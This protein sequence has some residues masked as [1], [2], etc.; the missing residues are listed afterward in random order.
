MMIVS[1]PVEEN[2]TQILVRML[3]TEIEKFPFQKSS[4]YDKNT[5]VLNW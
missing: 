5:L 2:F 3:E 4:L 1:V